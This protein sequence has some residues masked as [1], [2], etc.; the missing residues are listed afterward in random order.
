MCNRQKR[1]FITLFFSYKLPIVS[2]M[3]LL[4]FHVC[5]SNSLYSRLHLLLAIRVYSFFATVFDNTLC[6]GRFFGYNLYIR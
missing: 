3:Y 6:F 2:N 5:F 4:A 1:A